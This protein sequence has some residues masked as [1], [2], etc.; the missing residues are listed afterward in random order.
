MTYEEAFP[1]IEFKPIKVTMAGLKRGQADTRP[2]EAQVI[3][4]SE[5]TCRFYLRK[6]NARYHDRHHFSF[7]NCLIEYDGHKYFCVEYTREGYP[8]YPVLTARSVA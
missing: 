6:E 5:D 3:E 7:E 1:T 8:K 4:M 2:F